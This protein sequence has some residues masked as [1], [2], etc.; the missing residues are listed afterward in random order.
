MEGDSSNHIYHVMWTE[1]D[2]LGKKIDM[3]AFVDPT[4]QYREIDN[5]TQLQNTL[6]KHIGGPEDV[7]KKIERKELKIIFGF[8]V[9]PQLTS[10]VKLNGIPLL[11][12]K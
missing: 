2:S 1:D 7:I 4:F 11:E 9:K 10:A 8:E 6:R 12:K 3:N 5:Q